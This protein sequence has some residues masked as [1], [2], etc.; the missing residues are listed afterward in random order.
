M[1]EQMSG[2][3][4]PEPTFRQETANGL[5]V[6]VILRNDLHNRKRATE[7]DVAVYFGVELWASLSEQELEVAAYLFNNKEVQV[8]EVERMTG[9]HW[10]TSKRLMDSLVTKGVAV[11]IPGKFNRDP[12][13]VYRLK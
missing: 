7:R 13:A 12:R 10:R 3:K 5:V 8:T 11:Y 9:K 1:K 2:Y 4:L 6:K